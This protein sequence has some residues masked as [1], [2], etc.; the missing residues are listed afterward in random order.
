MGE[1]KFGCIIPHPPILVSGIG[2]R[3]LKQAEKSKKALE[4]LCKELKT[5]DFD[6]IIVITPHGKVGQASIPVYTSHV[7]EG[8]FVTFGMAKPNYSFKGD[9]DLARAIVKNCDFAATCSESL[10]DHGSLVP[11]HY[12][13]SAGIK[14]AIIPI[15][16]AFMPLHKL[17]E[18]GKF[19]AETVKKSSRKVAIIA[20]ADM[21]HRLTPDAPAGFSPRGREFD[22]KLVE[23]IENYDVNGIINF[24]PALAEEAGQDAVWSIAILLGALDGLNIKHELLS[25]EGPFGVGYMVARFEA[26]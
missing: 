22:D 25:Y 8:S 2:K 19:L 7:F 15:A 21:S 24:D 14:K 9:P 13:H 12:I 26:Q 1:I 5:Q 10:L 16:I 3:H 11:L 17:F 6:T 23:L 4:K 18:F 20:S